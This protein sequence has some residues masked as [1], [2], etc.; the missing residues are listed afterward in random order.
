MRSYRKYIHE[1]NEYIHFLFLIYLNYFLVFNL[2]KLVL[3]TEAN[4]VKYNLPLN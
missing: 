2:L 1:K 4:N 3:V